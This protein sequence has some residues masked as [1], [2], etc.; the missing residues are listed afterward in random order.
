MWFYICKGFKLLK[1]SKR[2]LCLW[3]LPMMKLE[4]IPGCLIRSGPPSMC[5]LTF[6][7]YWWGR[8]GKRIPRL[9]VV[10]YGQ[11]W[12]EFTSAASKT[13][14]CLNSK[15]YLSKLQ[16]VFVQIK[17]YLSHLKS[18]FEGYYMRKGDLGFTC[19]G[20]SSRLDSLHRVQGTVY[21]VQPARH[22]SGTT[23]SHQNNV[24]GTAAG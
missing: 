20:Y 24:Q 15:I 16:S 18:R 17:V 2:N 7:V 12:P 19:T 1:V 13:C 9:L 6:A 14:I 11:R 23:N 21:R 10:L 8:T 22:T 4:E 5:G 3:L